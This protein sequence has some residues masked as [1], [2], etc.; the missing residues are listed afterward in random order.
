MLREVYPKNW[1]IIFG[2]TFFMS[3]LSDED[4]EMLEYLF[5]SGSNG[6][7]EHRYQN[8]LKR[9]EGNKTSYVLKRVFVTGDTV[10]NYYPF[11]YKYPF[12]LPVLWIYRILRAI[13]VRRGR[14]KRELRF[15]FG[16]KKSND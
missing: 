11:F 3:K 13:F 10:R 6:A 7:S 14:T 4:K 15:L 8:R 16:N 1:N 12:F 5:T 9:N 2:G